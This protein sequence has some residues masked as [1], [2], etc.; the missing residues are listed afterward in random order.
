MK[1]TTTEGNSV[2]LW[3]RDHWNRDSLATLPQAVQRTI[4]NALWGYS[5][6]LVPR[7][8]LQS[9]QAGQPENLQDAQKIHLKISCSLSARN[10]GQQIAR[11]NCCSMWTGLQIS[12]SRE[13]NS[14][15]EPACV[16]YSISIPRK[17]LISP[18]RCEVR[19]RNLC[20]KSV[21]S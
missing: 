15:S 20:S 9:R 21:F 1:M 14:V 16:L 19:L 17:T 6:V 18:T 11:I 3:P 10:F 13:C 4:L 7:K 2:N 12:D 8:M 5:T